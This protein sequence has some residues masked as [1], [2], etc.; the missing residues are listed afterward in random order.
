MVADRYR[1]QMLDDFIKNRLLVKRLVQAGVP[2]AF[3]HEQPY[4]FELSYARPE[5]EESFEYGKMNGIVLNAPETGVMSWTADNFLHAWIVYTWYVQQEHEA[6]ILWDMGNDDNL[7][8]CV[9]EDT[10]ELL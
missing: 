10:E 2:I 7:C 6:V 1:L 4:R 8:Y 5:F 3:W 9:W